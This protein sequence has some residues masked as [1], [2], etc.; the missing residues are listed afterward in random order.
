MTTADAEIARTAGPALFETDAV[1]YPRGWRITAAALKIVA[2]GGLLAFLAAMLLS[3]APPS[4]PLKQIRLFLGL[5]AAPELAAW[6]IARAFATR[7]QIDGGTLLLVGRGE[8]VEVPLASIAGVS[9]WRLPVPHSGLWLDLRSGRRFA[10]AIQI[11]DAVA[12]VDAMIADGASHAI[13]QRLSDPVVVYARA[14]LAHP[15]GRLENPIVKFVLY[16]LVPTCIAWR[17]HQYI[18][19]GGTF[20]EYYTFGL[21][22]YVAGFGLWWASWSINLLLFAS[23]LR[24]I[25]E[26]VALAAATFS[27]SYAGRVRGFLEAFQRVAY[28]VGLPVW[29][30]LR[31]TA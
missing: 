20:G 3:D 12:M 28:Y 1:V 8:R 16:S 23:G 29:L 7:M 2:R 21:A 11:E 18:T 10:G 25:V 27:P 19:Y 6:C 31:L 5:F 26:I 30:A 22:A 17:L 4:N 14:R 13:R 15:L 9:P 24:A